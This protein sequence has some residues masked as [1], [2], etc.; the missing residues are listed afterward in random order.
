MELCQKVNRRKTFRSA[1]GKKRFVFLFQTKQKKDQEILINAN[2]IEQLERILSTT[3]NSTIQLKVIFALNNLALNEKFLERFRVKLLAFSSREKHFCFLSFA[4]KIVSK[5]V[6]ILP[7]FP[8]ESSTRRY[9]IQLLANLSLFDNL[10]DEFVKNIVDLDNFI[11]SNWRVYD[12]I[13]QSVK[14]LV[15]LSTNKSNIDAL[16]KLT[17]RSVF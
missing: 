3:T 15:N 13:L 12:E 6:E 10:H 2:C 7:K 16:F 9:A 17:V 1:V 14:I 5:I 11:A 8:S 4:Q